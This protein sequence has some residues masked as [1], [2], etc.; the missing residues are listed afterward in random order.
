MYEYTSFELSL[1]WKIAE[2]G[3]SGIM[4][5]VSEEAKYG[6]PYQTGLEIQILDNDKHPDGKNGTSHQAGALY[7]LVSPAADVTKPIGEWNTAVISINHE[8]NEGTSVLNGVEV[9]KFPVNGEALTTLLK[10]SKFD[11]WDGFAAYKTG[12]IALQDHGDK[13]SF[14]N[15]KIKEL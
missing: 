4:W 2:A 3:N 12:K 10:D 1:E 7:D 13:V 8:T 6:E 5:G 9:A 14:R 15:I 11:G